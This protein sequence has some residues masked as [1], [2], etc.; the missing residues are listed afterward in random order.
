MV[1]VQG[2]YIPRWLILVHNFFFLQVS[3]LLVNKQL[4][5][6]FLITNLKWA[7]VCYI[8]KILHLAYYGFCVKKV[9]NNLI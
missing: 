2:K 5:L 7:F 9:E 3:G 4:K 6:F 8:F 1:S